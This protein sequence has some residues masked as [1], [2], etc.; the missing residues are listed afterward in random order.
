MKYF[1]TISAFLALSKVIFSFEDI[2]K[3]ALLKVV[4]Y[5]CNSKPFTEILN[6]VF[7]YL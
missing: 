7:S 5:I 2:R 6:I 1:M 4:L 3:I